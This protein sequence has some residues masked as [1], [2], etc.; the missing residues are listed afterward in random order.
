MICVDLKAISAPASQNFYSLAKQNC[1]CPVVSAPCPWNRAR[2]S[3]VHCTLTIKSD[4]R[5]SDSMQCKIYIRVLHLS[6]PQQ[7]IMATRRGTGFP[8]GRGGVALWRGPLFSGLIGVHPP[9][10]AAVLAERA[11]WHVEM[12]RKSRPTHLNLCELRPDHRSLYAL[13]IKILLMI[14]A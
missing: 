5:N 10:R 4:D 13:G 9:V 1:C 14:A 6:R 3:N 2:N 7:S 12:V 8:R 11:G